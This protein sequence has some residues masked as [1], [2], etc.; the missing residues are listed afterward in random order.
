MQSLVTLFLKIPRNVD[1]TPEAT[2]TFL[3]A[4]TR[5]NKVSAAK[6]LFG[7]RAKP[8]ALEIGVV[9]QQIRFMITCDES[10]VPFIETQI[11]SSYPLV[12]I[13][14]IKDPLESQNVEVGELKLASGN[15]YPLA[16]YD[17]FS[18]VDPLSSVLSAFSKCEPTDFVLIQFALESVGN[19]WQS[20]GRLYAEHGDK[21]EDGSY[22]PRADKSVV[23]EKVSYP[24]FRAL[25]RIL[26]SKKKP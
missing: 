16:T 8:F 1:V 6:R 13:E 18:D 10:L 19:S 2:K 20:A 11:Q 17:R 24:G 25:V 14:R 22:T 4:L 7:V 15:F 21:N 23:I 5:I 26:A 3:L 9:N 12:I